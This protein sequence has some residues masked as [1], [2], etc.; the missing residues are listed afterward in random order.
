MKGWLL[1]IFKKKYI[2]ILSKVSP[3]GGKDAVVVVRPAQVVFLVG[4]L[5]RLHVAVEGGEHL[6][7][8]VS[9]PPLVDSGV[10]AGTDWNKFELFLLQVSSWRGEKLE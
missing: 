4:D 3:K 6:S 2:V 7:S 9:L 5:E 1:L 8:L 10:V